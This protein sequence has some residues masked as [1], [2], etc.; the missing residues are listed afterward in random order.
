MLYYPPPETIHMNENIREYYESR[1]EARLEKEYQ[2]FVA[3]CNYKKIAIIHLTLDSF[4]RRAKSCGYVLGMKPQIEDECDS[5]YDEK[6]S[7]VHPK[8]INIPFSNHGNSK[9][10]GRDPVKKIP[11]TLNITGFEMSLSLSGWHIFLGNVTVEELVKHLESGLTVEELFTHKPNG[12]SVKIGNR[13]VGLKLACKETGIPYWTMMKES[14]GLSGDDLQ[15][16][17]D[18]IKDRFTPHVRHIDDSVWCEMTNDDFDAL[19]SYAASQNKTTYD[20]LHQL[21]ETITY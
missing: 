7:F 10:G 1:V 18:S 15:K 3:K 13:I 9:S 17:F 14:K 12:R 8:V 2:W 21:I 16:C 4:K 11:N 20:A 6:I 19:K 5:V